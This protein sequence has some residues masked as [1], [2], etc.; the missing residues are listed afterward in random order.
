MAA[1]TRWRSPTPSTTWPTRFL[2]F[3]DNGGSRLYVSRVY[4]PGDAGD[5]HSGF[6]RSDDFTNG[7][8]VAAK[9]STF[10]ARFPGDAGNGL[11]DVIE[12][13]T[14]AT[15]R[16]MATALEGTCC[17]SAG[18][19]SPA[20][21]RFRAARRRSRSRTTASCCSTSAA[22]DA[23][24][25]PSTASPPRSPARR[26][27]TH[28]DRRHQPHAHGRAR[29]RDPGRHHSQQ[30]GDATG[31]PGRFH[32][33]AAHGRLRA[34]D[35]RSAARHRQRSQG[36]GV[37]GDGRA[38]AGLGFAADTSATGAANAANN[39]GDL[40]KVTA[41]EMN[42][43]AGRRR[44]GCARRPVWPPP[45]ALSSPR[46]RP[47]AA[48]TL[49]VRADPASAAAALGLAEGVTGHRHGRR[50][51]EFYVKHGDGVGGLARM[52]RSAWRGSVRPTTPENMAASLRHRHTWCTTDKDNAHGHLSGP[53]TRS[54]SPA[55]HRHDA[56]AQSEAAHRRARN[57]FRRRR[58]AQA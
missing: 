14:P 4:V 48:A 24:R 28:R 7:G 23:R 10:R 18:R 21:R 39:V 26:L 57:A 5:P 37:V 44:P 29:R 12:M 3:F 17:G 42:A 54:P 25:S 27:A 51:A 38:N 55:L 34:P 58:S 19:R 8:A 56:R 47:G 13:R 35:R 43:P 33:P 52:P 30:S 9:Q 16:A 46:R 36:H 32:Q 6:A 15:V 53:G 22:P 31:G 40:T 50:H 41:D 1:R 20:A 2:A 11:V 49:T 45:A